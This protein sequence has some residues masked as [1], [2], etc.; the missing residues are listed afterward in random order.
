M[1]D[2]DDSRIF[3][4][5]AL[6]LRMWHLKV[7]TIGMV[8]CCHFL[9]RLEFGTKYCTVFRNHPYVVRFR[10]KPSDR[11]S[12]GQGSLRDRAKTKADLK[13]IAHLSLFRL[14]TSRCQCWFFGCVINTARTSKKSSRRF[15]SL[16]LS[17]SKNLA[18]PLSQKQQP[19]EPQHAQ[20]RRL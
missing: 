13:N 1:I 12:T 17:P 15:L 10:G 9:F 20:S 2:D 3:F 6:L 19:R 8:H 7:C 14:L 18:A 11:N 5:R 16:S 4:V